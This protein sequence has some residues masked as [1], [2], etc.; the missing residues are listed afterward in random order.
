MEPEARPFKEKKVEK[1]LVGMEEV[2]AAL[3]E[4]I[5]TL[6]PKEAAEDLEKMVSKVDEDIE[7]YAKKD[8]MFKKDHDVILVTYPTKNCSH[9]EWRKSSKHRELGVL[10]VFSC[11]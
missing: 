5:A 4:V 2:G 8:E 1:N 11:P 3:M 7:T 6:D 9:L 10:E